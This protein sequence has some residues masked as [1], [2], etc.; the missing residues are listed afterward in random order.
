VN[1]AWNRVAE[2]G[3][4]VRMTASLA[5]VGAVRVRAIPERPFLLLFLLC[6]LGPAG[7]LQVVDYQRFDEL[8]RVK[9]IEPSFKD[10]A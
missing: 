7:D 8:E 3:R 2:G 1:S 6:P 5:A 4:R 9:G 10:K